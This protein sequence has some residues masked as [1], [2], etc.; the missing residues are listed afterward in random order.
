LTAL[1]RGDIATGRRFGRIGGETY[2]MARHRHLG[3]A[4]GGHDPGVCA[5]A[6]LGLLAAL[7]D[8]PEA[9]RREA[10]Q[11]IALSEAL[12]H[13]FNLVHAHHAAMARQFAGDREAAAQM[14]ERTIALADKYGFPPHR[15]GGLLLAAWSRVNR[16]HSAE[17]AEL[18]DAEIE[19]T[20]AV[21]PNVQYLLGIAGEIML[22]AGR[23]DHAVALLNRALAAN[24]EPDV[25]CY[26][27][28]IWRLRGACLLALDRGSKAEARQAFATARDLARRQGAIIFAPRRGVPRR[29]IQ[30][31]SRDPAAAPVACRGREVS[32]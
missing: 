28:E 19:R 15:S 18:V 29:Y 17:S 23:F 16:L 26:L 11:A 5:H 7:L 22:A 27:A 8:E 4:Y 2:D 14:A 3:P 1:F 9:A 12:D 31:V 10:A 24:E 32:P 6:V 21:G 25:G 13:P 30:S 20:A